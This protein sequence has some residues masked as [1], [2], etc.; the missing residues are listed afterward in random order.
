MTRRRDAPGPRAGSLPAGDPCG[1]AA[2]TVAVI[3]EGGEADVPCGTCTACCRAS[4][5]VH[6][7]PDEA[8]AL[9]RIPKAL[10]FPAPGLPP[11]HVLMGYDAEGRCPM[12]GEAGCTIYVDRPRTCRMYDCRV[13]A[14]TGVTP[15]HPAQRDIA[16]QA[17][18]WR[19]DDSTP[20]ARAVLE[21][22]R[23]AARYVR[24]HPELTEGGLTDTRTAVMAVTA[25]AA[26]L[27]RDA[28]GTVAVVADPDPG[29][30][31]TALA[32]PPGG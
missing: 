2:R 25:H 3:R 23:A 18:R 19:F 26:F 27:R 1:W 14:A 12:L 10:L 9:A 32:P 16:R 17:A 29:A 5:F 7:G 11:G 28:D 6:V 21:A 15:T 8:R 22:A 20:E 13:F 4:Q 30:V 24:A 31:A